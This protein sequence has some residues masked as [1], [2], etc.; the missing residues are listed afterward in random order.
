WNWSAN[1]P[2]ATPRPKPS[3][4]VGPSPSAIASASASTGQASFV[5]AGISLKVDTAA[6]AANPKDF[7][8]TVPKT[9][10]AIYAVFALKP[11]LAGQV[12]GVLMQGE[13]VLVTLSLQ[14]GAK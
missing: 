5:Q 3:G 9:A 4:S 8:T 13:K 12:N 11:G 6:Q 7:V 10:T 14:Y 2:V 1:I